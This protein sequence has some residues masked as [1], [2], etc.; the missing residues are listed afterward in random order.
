MPAL[1]WGL[2]TIPRKSQIVAI[3]GQLLPCTYQRSTTGHPKWST[4]GLQ[5]F[6]SLRQTLSVQFLPCLLEGCST[7]QGNN[8]IAVNTVVLPCC[9]NNKTIEVTTFRLVWPDRR[10]Q[11]LDSS[12]VVITVDTRIPVPPCMVETYQPERPPSGAGSCPWLTMADYVD[13]WLELMT[14]NHK[15][16]VINQ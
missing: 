1:E 13:H 16:P 7:S 3:A 14:C 4:M 8:D 10:Y 11:L 9:I 2:E 6:I 5:P 12:H 15:L